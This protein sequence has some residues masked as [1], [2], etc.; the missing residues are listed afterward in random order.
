MNL[1]VTLQGGV[2]RD[3]G[4]RAREA[5]DLGASAR[6]RREMLVEVEHPVAGPLTLLGTFSGTTS[7]ECSACRC[8]PT[9]QGDDDAVRHHLGRRSH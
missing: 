2:L 7:R 1:G 3:A 6:L 5:E 8:E 9:R 4:V